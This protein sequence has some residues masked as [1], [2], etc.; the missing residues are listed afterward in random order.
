MTQDEKWMQYYNLVKKFYIHNG[1]LDI[2]YNFKTKNGYTKNKKGKNIDSWFSRQLKLYKE[3]KLSLARIN[4]LN[5]LNISEYL[6]TKEER[7]ER[8]YNLVKIYYEHNKTLRMHKDF[9]T[10]DG[11]TYNP[12]GVNIHKWKA[13]QYHRNR[14]GK[15]NDDEKNKLKE[16]GFKFKETV[17]HEKDWMERYNLA[18]AYYKHYKNLKISRHFITKDGITECDDGIDLGAW[19][20]TQIDAYKNGTLSEKRIKLLK[21]IGMKFKDHSRDAKWKK[22]YKLAKAYYKKHC[23]L[24]VPDQFYTKNGYTYNKK[25]LNLTKWLN[26]QRRA[27]HEEKL[28]DEKL[29]LLLKLNFDFNKSFKDYK[30][31]ERYALAKKYYEYYNHLNVPF[32][33]KTKNGVDQDELGIN[34]GYWIDTQRKEYRKGKLSPEKYLRLTE[35]NMIWNIKSKETRIVPFCEEKGI[36]ILINKD[37]L[38]TITYYELV[39][40][41]NFLEA[42]GFEVSTNGKLHEIF[43]MCNVNMQLKYNISLEE[44]IINYYDNNKK[45]SKKV[46]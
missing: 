16:I 23:N 29:K 15:L 45:L 44:V 34:L 9:K 38:N 46:D 35:L 2:P 24:I 30:W 3:G 10:L 32:G 25:G 33:F 20:Y 19:I 5:E 26:N 4:L 6:L 28:S 11:I 1:H 39:A 31:D 18:K 17:D 42:N 22:Y 14:I 40:K 37:V 41:A 7:W 12:K 21:E 27:Y 36:D 13:T 43:Y 8:A